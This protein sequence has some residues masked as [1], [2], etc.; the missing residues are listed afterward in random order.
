MEEDEGDES[1]MEICLGKRPQRRI[2]GVSVDEK[3]SRLFGFTYGNRRYRWNRLPEVWKWSMILFHARVAEIVQGIPCLQYANNILIG[4]ESVEELRSIA[5]QVFARFDE[6]GIKVNFEK[7]KWVSETIQSLG[8]EISNA[9]WSHEN[10]LKQNLAELGEL[11]TIK[12]LERIIGVIS[13]ARRCVK[14]VEVI[15]G[16]LREG[17]KTVKDDEVSEVWLH[18]L[19]EQVKKALKRVLANVRWLMLPGVASDQFTF[20]IESDCRSKHAGYMLFASRDDEEMLLDMGSRRQNMVSSSYLGELDALVW[21]C[22]RTKSFRGATPVVVRTD[23]HAL[24]KKW[25]SRSL[26]DSGVRIFRRWS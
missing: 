25:R 24:V 18:V 11:R 20:V 4:A 17:L 15:L 9:H 22:K 10:F 21:A 3:L 5:H 19:H 2:F 8:W 13:Y 16:P 6:Y 7:V 23:N 26:Y 1:Q 14:D 12:D